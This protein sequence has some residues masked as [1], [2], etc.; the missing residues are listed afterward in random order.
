MLLVYESLSMRRRDRD[1]INIIRDFGQIEIK[2]RNARRLS[3]FDYA[4]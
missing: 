1:R 2:R 3:E 4:D